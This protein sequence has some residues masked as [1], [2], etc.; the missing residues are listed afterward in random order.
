MLVLA[1]AACGGRTVVVSPPA[2][3][4]AARL[5]EL[6]V[7][8]GPTPRDLFWGVGGR[9]YAPPPD[10]S[11]RLVGKDE[12]GFSV[13]FDVTS[14]DDLEWS[15]KIGPEAQTEVVVSRVLWGLGYHQPPVYYLPSWTLDAA[16]AEPRK[17]SEARF[18]P[19]LRGLERQSDSWN[20]A[21]N[22]FSG[23]RELKGLLVVLLIMNSTDLKD[24]NNS[25]Y[26]VTAPLAGIPGTPARWFLV[27]DLGAALGETGKLYPRRNW[28]DA[29]E[30]E[31]FITSI[32]ESTVEFDY[33][34]RHQELLTMIRPDD[35][36]WAAGQLARLTETQW[37]DAFRAGNY[38]RPQADRYIRR[39]REKIADGLALRV[40]PR[41]LAAAD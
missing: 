21:D 20:W 11:Y 22:P 18:R 38:A 2:P 24:S 13:S 37:Q 33:D 14:P 8:P 34:G 10:A 35:V 36:R 41:T 6:R 15:A 27:R 40:D 39:I 9:R 7:D 3:V 28:L 16:G 25:V 5:V 23:T 17:E 12:T 19:K 29:F 26:E 32:S 31:S 30:K 4:S 1:T